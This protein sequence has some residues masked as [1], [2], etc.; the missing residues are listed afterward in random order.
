MKRMWPVFQG[1][2]RHV[3]GRAKPRLARPKRRWIVTGAAGSLLA[4]AV[5]VFALAGSDAADTS[6][7]E[8]ATATASIE[9][10]DLTESLKETGDLGYSGADPV[11]A[12]KSGTVT[13]LPKRGQVI[14]RGG[15]LLE[16]DESPVSLMF[17]RVPA[18]RDLENGVE[19]GIDVKQLERNLVALGFDPHGEIT[20]DDEFTSAT[21]SAVQ[22]WQE[23]LGI[24]E[25]GVVALGDVVFMEGRRRISAL[26]VS[27]GAAIGSAGNAGSSPIATGVQAVQARLVSSSPAALSAVTAGGVAPPA[28]GG[29][30]TPASET[31]GGDGGGATKTPP[32]TGGGGIRPDPDTGG[33][34][35]D[36]EPDRMKP[37]VPRPGG[38]ESPVPG[39][40]PTAGGYPSGTASAAARPGDTT[41]GAPSTEVMDTSSDRRAV[42]VDLDAADQGFARKGANATVDMPGGE[43]ATGRVTSVA[44]EAIDTNASAQ[45]SA[46]GGETESDLVV[47][48]VIRLDRKAEK[49]TVIEEAPVTVELKRV[50]AEDVLT[51]PVTA[52]GAGA[53][54]GYTVTVVNEPGDPETLPVETGEFSDGYVEIRGD[55]IRAG[56][57]VQVPE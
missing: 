40:A 36:G 46:T 32:V 17:G 29:E 23:D 57:K 11:I 52:V 51:V 35:P 24:G 49:S 44:T 1:R 27:L 54:G 25:T 39:P 42:T 5:T 3:F 16:I 7:R 13:W 34:T 53:G 30:E 50:V 26:N 56:L 28:P 41:G 15:R 31:G 38:S 2:V 6:E 43:E 12:R 4:G 55:G 20:V 45:A 14:P 21:T 48:V 8:S 47:E 18:Y 37:A 22:R 9:K 10:R 33:A 19:D